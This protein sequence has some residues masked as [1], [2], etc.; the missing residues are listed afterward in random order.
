M[1]K[2]PDWVNAHKEK[3]TSIKK[4][5]NAYYLYKTT[6]KRIPGKKYPQPIETYIGVITEEGVSRSQVRKI[7]TGSVK[8]Y[9][10][11]MS[12]AMKALLPEAFLINGHDKETMY[13]VFLLII[14]HVSPKS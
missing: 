13:I 14:K 2:Y 7:S 9:E 4:I 10:Y 3:G 12:Y 5:G 11:G 8:V 6:S 1:S